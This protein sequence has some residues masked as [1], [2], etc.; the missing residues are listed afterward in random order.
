MNHVGRHG[1]TSSSSIPRHLLFQGHFY[2]DVCVCVC[3][4]LFLSRSAPAAR[5]HPSALITQLRLLGPC[6][7]QCPSS[8]CASCSEATGAFHVMAP[9][10]KKIKKCAGRSREAKKKI[11][12]CARLQTHRLSGP[13]RSTG[14]VTLLDARYSK[15]KNK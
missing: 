14:R 5:R 1:H 4:P 7:S 3:R 9:A 6:V 11:S 12:I 13:R 15:K 10:S 2:V 8:I